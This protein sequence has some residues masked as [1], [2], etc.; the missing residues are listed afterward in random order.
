VSVE[1]TVAALTRQNR[2]LDERLSRL[3][4]AAALLGSFSAVIVDGNFACNGATPAAPATYTPSNVSADRA[5]D[6]NSTTVDEIA[7]V[8]GTLI[9]D[10]KLTGLVA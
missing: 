8:L 10:L 5:F 6:A 4:K 2:L 3:E 7:D 9:A 1:D